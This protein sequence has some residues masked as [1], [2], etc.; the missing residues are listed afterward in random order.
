MAT[1][2]TSSTNGANGTNGLHSVTNSSSLNHKSSNHDTATIGSPAPLATAHRPE[3][4]KAN[5]EGIVA[6]FSEFS[7]LIHSPRK[8]LPT[9]NGSGTASVKRTQTGLRLD[10]KYIGWK[11]E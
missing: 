11:G 1:T 2:G 7:Q 9:Q 3:Q 6:A 8:P 10:L 5:R 4:L